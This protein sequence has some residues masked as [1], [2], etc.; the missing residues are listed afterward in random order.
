MNH[1][2]SNSSTL[3]EPAPARPSKSELVYATLRG[4]IVD[5]ARA[6]GEFIDK[7]EVCAKLAVS[8]FPVAEALGRLARDK[9][10]DVEPQRGSYVAPIRLPDIEEALF[11]RAAVESM[12]LRYLPTA[13]LPSLGATLRAIL[14]EQAEAAAAN[15]IPAL[16]ATDV[17]FHAAIVARAGIERASDLVASFRV[18]TDRLLRFRSTPPPWSVLLGEHEAICA[19]IERGDGD[20]ASAALSAH[21]E[22][23]RRRVLAVFTPEGALPE[24]C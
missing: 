24:P 21:I 16:N 7:A 17:A 11:L 10:V 13:E 9:L 12:A 8:R 15:D 5:L 18:H 3:A 20:G 14:D 1:R 6:P 19:A 4:E 2:S 23:L 22:G